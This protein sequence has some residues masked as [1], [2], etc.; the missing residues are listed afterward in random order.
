MTTIEGGDIPFA[1]EAPGASVRIERLRFV[2]P[3]PF[4]DLCGRSGRTE[5]RILHDRGRGTACLFPAIRR[6]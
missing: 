5:D 2:R 4:R 6:E 1:V 3:K